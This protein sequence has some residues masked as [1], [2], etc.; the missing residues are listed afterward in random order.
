MT[1]EQRSV[2]IPL[3]IKGFNGSSVNKSTLLTHSL[4]LEQQ[5]TDQCALAQTTVTGGQ[6]VYNPWT[7]IGGVASS[8]TAQSEFILYVCTLLLCIG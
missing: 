7:I 4:M 3:I 8:V 6:T 2:V 5:H 1:P